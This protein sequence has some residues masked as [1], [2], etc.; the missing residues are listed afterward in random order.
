MDN[1][2]DNAD[3][4][5]VKAVQDGEVY[6]IPLGM[7]R[8]YP[9]SSDTPL[10]LEWFAKQMYPEKFEDVDMNTE[11]KEYYSEFYGIELTDEDVTTIFNPSRE[12]ANGV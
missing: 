7:Y 1:T 12:A 9:P 4:G 11:V 5:S 6:K 2:I 8:W 3:W 10:M